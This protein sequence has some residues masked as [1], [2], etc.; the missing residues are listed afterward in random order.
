MRRCMGQR[1]RILYDN[2]FSRQVMIGRIERMY[3]DVLQG[4]ANAI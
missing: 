4:R 1:S 3:D 2:R